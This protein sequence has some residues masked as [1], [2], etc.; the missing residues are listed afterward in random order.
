[1]LREMSSH[2]PVVSQPES[3][4]GLAT[5]AIAMSAT[6]FQ[7]S[8]NTFS[9]TQGDVV[10]I[11]LSVP[12]NDGSPSGHGLVMD[13][14]VPGF[15]V[16][17]GQSRS[18]TFTATTPGTFPFACTQ[19][20]CGSGHSNMFG[21]MVVTAATN[22]APS[23]S[24][25]FPNSGSTAGGTTVII[26]GANFQTTG[27][28]TVKFDNA[29]ATSVNV[30]SS[31]SI[32]VVTPAHAEG[33]VGV[34]V[35]NPDGQSTTLANAYT[36]V[37]SGPRIDSISPTTGSTAGGTPITIT[38]AGFVNGAKV[39]IGG[40]PASNVVVASATSITANTPLG[41]AND[42]VNVAKDVVVTNPDGLSATKAGAFTYFVPSLAVTSIDPTVGVTGGGT[43]V[44]ITGAGFTTAVTSSVTFGGT[45]ATNVQ[46]LDAVTLEA[47][48]PAHAAGTV[49]VVVRMGGS[50]VTK[51]NA[52]SF[53]TPPPRKRS[54]RH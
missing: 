29:N 46:V 5:R 18:V 25:I 48:A 2:G 6:Q 28:T 37:L 40:L 33:L 43:V 27:T 11:T 15:N 12:S 10:T 31:T 19:S 50:S 13:T 1:M 51:S 41:P 17:K 14:Y 20:N 3:I 23:I 4:E 24:N 34:T 38:G 26:S 22:P 54:V 53:Q 42:Q 52:F 30:T 7:F 45:A 39:T 8:P 49:D 32:S 16:S 44:R 36:Y 35:T 47:T 21:Q 9:V